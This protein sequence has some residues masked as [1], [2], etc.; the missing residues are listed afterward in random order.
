MDEFQEIKSTRKKETKKRSRPETIATDDKQDNIRQQAR[1]YC[2]NIEDWDRI[3][4][5]NNEQ[6]EEF[7][8][9]QQF[10]QQKQITASV[11]GAVHNM[12]SNVIDKIT[13]GE[14]YVYEQL[15]S[16]VSLRIALEEEAGQYIQYL[17]NKVRIAALMMV[18]VVQGK[19][20]QWKENPTMEV[21]VIEKNEHH[22]EDDQK[23][24]EEAMPTSSDQQ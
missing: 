11:F 8:Q 21:D 9:E 22:Q 3:K 19:R 24:Q 12:L 6:L 20:R 14:S 1:K 16:D 2:K 13:H 18:D 4:E 23:E 5:L 7:V 10:I 17:T 15:V